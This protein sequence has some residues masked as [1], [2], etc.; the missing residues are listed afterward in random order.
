MGSLGTVHRPGPYVVEDPTIAE[1][2]EKYKADA[3]TKNLEHT[4]RQDI[5]QHFRLRLLPFC[6]GAKVSHFAFLTTLV[7]CVIA[8]APGQA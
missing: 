8:S 3:V 6:E 4:T 2:V 1:A 5:E 7:S